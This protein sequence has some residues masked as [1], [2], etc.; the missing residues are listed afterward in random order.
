[1]IK[2]GKLKFE[3]S[4]RSV[5]VEDL[6]EA[7]PEM[8]RQEEKALRKAGSGKAAIPRDEVSISKDKRCE[9]SGSLT[10]KRS[11]ER[12][13][14]PNKEEKKETLQNMIRELELMLKEQKEYSTALREEYH[15]QTLGQ[16][17]TLENDDA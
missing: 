14:K 11:K 17:Q 3:E 5:G 6:F 15:R 8:I 13:C 10:T 7:K 9:V 16:G 12:L 1:M 4:D 2:D